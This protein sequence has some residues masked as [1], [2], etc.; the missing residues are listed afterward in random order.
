MGSRHRIKDNMAPVPNVQYGGWYNTSC[1]DSATYVER[2][3]NNSGVDVGEVIV[4]NDVVTPHF[5]RR[6]AKGEMI[7]NDFQTSRYSLEIFGSTAYTWR[8]LAGT[9]CPPLRYPT[10]QRFGSAFARYISAI[11]TSR[12]AFWGPIVSGRDMSSHLIEEVWTRCLANRQAGLT[13]LSE[14]LAELDKAYAMVLNPLENLLKALKAFKKLKG[15]RGG[16]WIKVW[17]G[18]RLISVFLSS[19]WLRFRYGIMPLVNDVKAAIKAL[20]KAYELEPRRMRTLA[21]GSTS[22]QS[23][24]P[25]YTVQDSVGIDYNRV[26]TLVVSVRAFA[27]DQAEPSIWN[28]LG[29]SFH[30]AIGLAWE[31]THFS[32]VADW[33]AN[34]G[35]LFYANIPRVGVRYLGGGVTVKAE[36]T[37]IYVPFRS[38][39]T[40]PTT[41]ILTGGV[42]DYVRVKQ[43]SVT[44]TMRSD[45]G[46]LVIRDDFRY[47]NYNR[48]LDTVALINEQLRRLAF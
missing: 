41:W 3:R 2:Y 32:F 26:S 25:L 19:E 5:K 13:N 9:N 29:L 28:D 39:N 6:I 11:Y 36:G 45:T 31:L 7:F 17:K 15:N 37:M 12:P 14:S 22:A 10:Y 43:T 20:R 30:N 1:A 35:D 23:T 16:K 8:A 38:T 18:G 42:T 40:V 33:F 44:R 27:Y 47:W 24:T 34:V 46:S 4:T 21:F 48:V